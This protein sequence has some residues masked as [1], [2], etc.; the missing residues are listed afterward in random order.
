MVENVQRPKLLMSNKLNRGGKDDSGL[1]HE[2]SKPPAS[3]G[4]F[5]LLFAGDSH[6]DVLFLTQFEEQK[7][8]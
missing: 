8:T 2:E 5:L 4:V 3:V 1:P 6:F 7:F